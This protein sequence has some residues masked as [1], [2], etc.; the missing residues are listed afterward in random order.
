M[1][2]RIVRRKV[3]QRPPRMRTGSR[4]KFSSADVPHDIRCSRCARP[5]NPSQAGIDNAIQHRQITICGALSDIRYGTPPSKPAMPQTIKS[6]QASAMRNPRDPCR[7]TRMETM[8]PITKP[9]RI[10]RGTHGKVQSCHVGA[11]F[12]VHAQAWLSSRRQKPKEYIRRT[13][14][15]AQ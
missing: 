5:C 15:K 12:P 13:P 1:L 9:A 14:S 4:P 6:D 3:P 11:P 8:T 2:R 10:P 7:R